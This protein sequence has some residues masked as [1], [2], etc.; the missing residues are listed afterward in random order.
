MTHA[1]SFARALALSGLALVFGCSPSVETAS[2]SW[3]PGPRQDLLIRDVAVLDVAT[4]RRSP[5][6][7]VFVQNGRIAA[8]EAAGS[9]PVADLRVIHGAGGTLLPGLIDMHGHVT[10]PRGPLWEAARG[11][12]RANLQSYLYAGVTTVL[13]PADSTGAGPQRRDRIARGELLGPRVYTSGKM[14][15]CP[16]GHPV[17]MIELFAPSWLSWFVTAGVAH[18]V[19]T[20]EDAY[21]AIDA[22]VHEG[23]DVIK[24]AVD[25]IPPQAPRISTET[26]E[27]ID[28]RA[29]EHDIRW[30]AHIGTLQDA[31]DAGEAGGSLWVHGLARERISDEDVARLAGFGIPMVV[32]IEVMD[33]MLRGLREPIDPIAME[34]ETV[35]QPVLDSFYPPPDAY[36]EAFEAFS[37]VGGDGSGDLDLF[38]ISAENMRKLRRAGVTILAGS[39]SQGGGIFPGASL[40]RELAQLVRAGLTPAEAIRAATV[41]SATWLANGKPIEFGA[42]RVGLRADLLLVSGDPTEDIARLQDIAAVVVGGTPVERRAV[43][44][45]E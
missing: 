30:V 1:R 18:Q 44:R 12:P 43:A 16:G 6:R 34:L 40:H 27:A 11:D 3:P 2:V 26:L 35:P 32:T 38:A 23:V 42:I 24:V 14:V 33:R 20:R 45:V 15:T 41:D 39:D 29:R 4:G 22:L 10:L 28:E 5:S 7:D 37:S 31:L 13:D 25:R 36:V 19:E 9:L 21:E 17:A 8:I